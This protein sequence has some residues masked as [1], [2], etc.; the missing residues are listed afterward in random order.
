MIKESRAY[1][2]Q[3]IQ[4]CNSS[5]SEIIDMDGN[6]D[7]FLSKIDKHFKI[8]FGDI[9]SEIEGNNAYL[10]RVPVQVEVYKALNINNQVGDYDDLYDLAICIKDTIVDPVKVKATSSITDII[11]QGITPEALPT[12]DKVFKMILTFEIRKDFQ[13]QGV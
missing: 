2:K 4:L 8:I 11:P 3:Q 12:G 1:I 5:Y 10:D 9:S 7:I 6:N 13:Y